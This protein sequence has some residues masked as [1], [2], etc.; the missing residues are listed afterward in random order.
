MHDK[1]NAA[2]THAEVPMMMLSMLPRIWRIVAAEKALSRMWIP[3]P[4]A[5]RSTSSVFNTKSVVVS[6]SRRAT[7]ALLYSSR[8]AS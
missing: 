3:S 7:D 5:A 4:T 2:E 1:H 8:L 6:T